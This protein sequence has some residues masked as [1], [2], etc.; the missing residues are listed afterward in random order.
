VVPLEP[1]DGSGNAAGGK[2]K[3]VSALNL[4]RLESLRIIESE[5]AI[6]AKKDGVSFTPAPSISA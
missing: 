3:Q 6:A 4:A 2:K 1:V 5:K